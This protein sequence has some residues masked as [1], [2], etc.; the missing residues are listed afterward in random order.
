MRIQ[1][2]GKTYYLWLV[3]AVLLTEVT[4]AV[5]IKV[6]GAEIDLRVGVAAFTATPLFVVTLLE[7]ARNLRLQ[8]AAFIKDYVSQFFINP[9]LYQTFHELIYTYPNSTFERLEHIR[10]EQK[11]DGYDKPVFE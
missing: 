8:R 11:L 10:K 7:L 1:M 6:I 9:H 5:A 2:F 4:I 3:L